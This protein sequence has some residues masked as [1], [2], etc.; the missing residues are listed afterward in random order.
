V[1]LQRAASRGKAPV[2]RRSVR[3]MKTAPISQPAGQIRGKFPRRLATHSEQRRPHGADPLQCRYGPQSSLSGAAPPRHDTPGNPPP[4]AHD[5]RRTRGDA[6]ARARRMSSTC[7][8]TGGP[9]LPDRRLIGQLIPLRSQ[10]PLSLLAR[11][12][13]EQKCSPQSPPAVKRRACTLAARSYRQTTRG[14]PRQ[15]LRSRQRAGAAVP[16]AAPDVR[17]RRLERAARDGQKLPQRRDRP[18]RK[19]RQCA[20]VD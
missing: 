20:P 6:V 14:R 7:R 17:L 12:H 16:G 18:R 19:A 3:R 15:H 4:T 10:V 8:A 13:R 5:I 2:G 9:E 1:P 11:G